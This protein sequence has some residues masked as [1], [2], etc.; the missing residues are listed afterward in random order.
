M[1][2]EEDEVEQIPRQSKS[3]ALDIDDDEADDDDDEE[4]TNPEGGFQCHAVV[5]DG[6]PKGPGIPTEVSNPQPCLQLD[7]SDFSQWQ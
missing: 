7:R 1:Q 6:L 2:E 5:A 3:N 4:Y